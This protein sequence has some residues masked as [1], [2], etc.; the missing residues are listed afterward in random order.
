MLSNI[1]G[2]IRRKLNN[3]HVVV[4]WLLIGAA[5]G[6]SVMVAS[7]NGHKVVV[8]NLFY[9]PVVLGGFF[10][11]RYRAGVMALLCVIA[12][13]LALAKSPGDFAGAQSIVMIGLSM[14]IWGAVL[15]L[16]ALLVGSLSDERSEERRVGEECRCGWA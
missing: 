16:A 15:C 8:L 3:D 4:E 5:L 14:L 10:L 2:G 9:L 6:L 12:A 1:V 7:V 11:G 13:S